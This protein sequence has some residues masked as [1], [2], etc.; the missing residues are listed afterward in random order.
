MGAGSIE[1]VARL[2]ERVLSVR[3][4]AGVLSPPVAVASAAAGPVELHAT[5]RLLGCVAD[6]VGA[7]AFRLLGAGEAAPDV[8]AGVVGRR[9]DLSAAWLREAAA[10]PPEPPDVA[11]A[12][13]DVLARSFGAA[14]RR[15]ELL[16]PD[17]AR[18]TAY[19][20]G[21]PA[22]PA[23]VL[24]SAC[25]MP[26][27]LSEHWVRRLQRTHHVVTWESRWLFGPGV[28]DPE[29]GPASDVAAQAADLI[30]VMDHFGVG[31]AHL[32]GLCGGAVIALDAAVRW[33]ARFTSMSLWHGDFELGP[34]APKTDHQRNLQALL[35]M[36]RQ[37]RAG[38]AAVH[39]V[40]SNSLVEQLPEDM[41]HLVIY[42]YATGELWYRYSLLNGAIMATD[43]RG[44]LPRIALPTLV[45]T[46]ADDTTAHPDGSIAVARGLD[47]VTLHIAPHG[48][49]ISLFRGP[50][51]LIDLALDFAQRNRP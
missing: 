27:E 10:D 24:A 22:A 31:R 34:V 28:R 45:V 21:D 18:L 38:S 6:R 7:G 43:V 40:L 3:P 48:D 25:G 51:E 13:A 16:R 1:A 35:D 2:T 5:G 4:L 39:R 23:V 46:S 12:A 30:A 26:V 41:A 11:A 50:A 36:A 19:A 8:F 49:H 32:M 42:P 29:D 37:G 20:A 44:H 9:L 17:G 15:A 33:P 14:C 47:E